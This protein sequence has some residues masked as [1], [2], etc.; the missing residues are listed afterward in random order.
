MSALGSFAS[1]PYPISTPTRRFRSVCC[2]LTVNGPA[3]AAPAR[4]VMKSR[5]L[6]LSPTVARR[7]QQPEFS[8]LRLASEEQMAQPASDAMSQLGHSRRFDHAPTTS[9]LPPVNRHSQSRPACLK[10]ANLGSSVVYSITRR[11]GGESRRA[12][13]F[14]S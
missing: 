2:A 12:R 8:T 4:T 6:M 9:G 7:V 11:R 10:R 1:F 3:N 13:P 14:D 5:R